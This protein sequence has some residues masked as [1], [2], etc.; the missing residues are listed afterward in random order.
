MRFENVETFR[1]WHCQRNMFSYSPAGT[2][3]SE[4]ARNSS[5]WI[6]LREVYVQSRRPRLFLMLRPIEIVFPLVLLYTP[7]RSPQPKTPTL[8]DRILNNSQP[9]IKSKSV[10][11]ITRLQ[12]NESRT[13][14]R[15]TSASIFIVYSSHRDPSR[16]I[17]KSAKAP[18]DMALFLA[19]QD[20]YGQIRHGRSH[21]SWSARSCQHLLIRSD[22]LLRHRSP[23]IFF[24]NELT[25]ASPHLGTRFI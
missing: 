9:R 17:V 21:F 19:G 22:K 23:R 10:K 5:L 3:G 4:V 6:L 11:R 16:P 2:P 8:K 18:P 14:C 1:R 13:V 24:F 25:S 7:N 20:D 12:I 15:R